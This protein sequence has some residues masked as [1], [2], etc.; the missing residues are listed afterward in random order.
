[1]ILA[2]FFVAS[3]YQWS[4]LRKKFLVLSLTNPEELE[5]VGY[6]FDK[7]GYRRDCITC[8]LKLVYAIRACL[9]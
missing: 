8:L 3:F 2:I 1:M 7:L 5:Y 9:S 6:M 4:R